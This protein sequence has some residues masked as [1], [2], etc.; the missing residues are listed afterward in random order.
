MPP[1]LKY[2]EIH[3]PDHYMILVRAFYIFSTISIINFEDTSQWG[4]H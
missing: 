2:P 1:P 4:D 3:S